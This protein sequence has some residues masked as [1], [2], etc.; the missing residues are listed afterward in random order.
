MILSRS[1]REALDPLSDVLSALGVRSVRSTRFEASGDWALAFPGKA[2][3]KFVALLR[4]RCWMLLP[5]HPP[6]ALTE[7]DVFLIGDTPYT[8]ASDPAI[9]PVDGAPFYAQPDHDV[10]RLGDG[11]QTGLLGGSVDFADGDAAFIL[12]ALP[13]F[14]RVDRASPGAGAVVRTL[15]CLEAELG[16]DR[17]GAPLIT[18]RLA[19][20]LMVE[21]IRAYIAMGA[22]DRVGWIGALA[23]RQV[24]AALRLMHGEV[25][26]PWTV[27]RLAA[28]VG[29]SRSAFSARFVARVGRPPL[30]YLTHWRMV[31]ARRLLSVSQGRDPIASVAA[32]V[33]YSSQ[34]AFAHA[35]KRT[36]G[37]PPRSVA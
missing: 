2:R 26:E 6:E 14:L 13:A 20:I 8:V 5:D 7:G 36:F 37:Y 9:E 35:F 23:D 4:G 28:R 27:A 19:E 21:A 3:L 34:S 33:G 17:P 18:D 24:G 25:A 1:S 29:M 10:L 16:E 12:E 32:E 31:L 22:E 30:D 11:L 15:A